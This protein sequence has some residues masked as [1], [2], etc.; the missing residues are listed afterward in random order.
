VK[1]YDVVVI[2]AG[3]GGLSSATFLA[4]AGKKV[5]LLE[6]HNVPGGYASSFTRGRFEFEIALHELSGLGNESNKGPVWRIL[7]E[8]GVTPRVEF[9]PIPDFYRA[10]VLPDVDVI[11]PI[12]REN[13]ED[14]LC[15]QFPKDAE[16]IKRFSATMFDFAEEALRANRVGM[17]AVMEEPSKFSTLLANYGRT[18]TEVLN[19]LVSD[20]RARAVLSETCG[21]YCQPPSKMSFLIYALGT[22]SYLRF[23]PAHIKGKSQ[24]LSQAF[25][26]AIE[27]YGGNVWLNNG[28]AR[29]LTSSGG[30]RG[31]VAEDGTEIACKYVVCNANPLMTCLDFI[32]KENIP[33]WYLKRL[34]AW[35]GG[36][37]TFNV[38]LG[39]DCTCSELGLNTHE[40]FINIRADL[41]KQ[42]ESMRHSIN[43]EPYG[44]A[45]TAY[46][47]VDEEF[48]PPGTASLVL[49]TLAYAEPWL[50][51]SPSEYIK[52]KDLLA[53]KFIGLAERIAPGLRDHIEVMEIATPLTNVRYTGNPGGSIIGFDENYQ[54]TGQVHL[55]N[56][57]PLEG[58]Y[59]AGAW[60][61]I[62][63]GFETCIVS[64]YLAAKEALEDMEREGHDVTIME[65][66][67]SQ[68]TKQAERAPQLKDT[69]LAQ[70]K[71][72]VAKLHPDRVSLKVKDVIEETQSTKTLRMVSVEGT[73]PYFRAGQ[74]INLFV[75][76]DGILTSRPYSISSVPG[77]PYYDITVRRIEPG[78]VSHYLLD[79]VTVGDT[80][81][82]TG[83]NGSFYYEP[84]IET[85][86]LVFLA[87]GSGI[88]P[89]MSMIREV[90]QKQSP[91]NIHLLYGSRN[92]TDIIFGDELMKLAAKYQNIKV[93]FVISEPPQGWSGLCGLLDAKMISSLVGSVESKKFFLCGPAQMHILCEGALKTL[94][95]P[96]RLVKK[97]AYGPPADIT[98]EP[99]WPRLSP[100][101]EFEVIE[102]RSGRILKARAGEPL[103]V[104]LERAGLVVPA[105]CR[106]G[107][108]TA[109]RTRLV[110][111][112]V[113][114]PARVHRR[115]VDEKSNYIHPCMSYPLENLRIRL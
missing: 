27:E 100:K 4:K 75:N 95:V 86:D 44:A 114:A 48:S 113:F 68:L 30:V 36:A 112:K 29:I 40:N 107:E 104:S 108:C 7:K 3:L 70:A 9:I 80:F 59:F 47:V 46:N 22:V 53:D 66:L 31:V 82:S 71:K 105:I 69:L 21:Y 16:G 72:T 33:G 83:P 93:D 109:C 77:K 19:P 65:K 12:G 96:P 57:G 91:V 5:L 85:S 55:P 58:L 26:D 2:G 20:D 8:Y 73:L 6:K 41:D 76:I 106:S 1:D 74:Y 23:G 62:G 49:T 28:A 64:G 50:K 10:V 89:F 81:E 42:H 37:S 84:L 17:K 115:W 25:V 101:T 52:M 14:A 102:E 98:L 67:Q 32:G 56:R 51:L 103:M 88:T 15:H 45:V 34:G 111:G 78:F 38:Y 87:G 92:H 13:F 24:A 97:E 54:G 94:G 61:N 63:G 79:R 60:V 43:L 90:T 35:S 11:V 110:V 39:L 99:G 18:L